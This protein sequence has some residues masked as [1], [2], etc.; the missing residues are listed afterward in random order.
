MHQL[1]ITLLAAVAG[2]ATLLLFYRAIRTEWPSNYV[3]VET[4]FGIVINRS[5]L[6]YFIFTLGPT[7]LVS[8]FAS[9]LADRSGGQ[10]VACALLIA[11]VHIIR[12]NGRHA[13]LVV[14]H[15]H[16]QAR[17][18]L[19]LVDGFNIFVVVLAAL[20]GAAGPGP[21]P[22][23]VPPAADFFSSLWTTAFVAVV[24]VCLLYATRH[25]ITIERLLNRSS[26][27]TRALEPVARSLAAEQQTEPALALA[28][29]Y[30]ENLQRPGW[31]R[32]LE[33]AKG[34]LWPAG[35]YGV[36]QI[37]SDRPFVRCRVDTTSIDRAI[38]RSTDPARRIRL[39]LGRSRARPSQLQR[40]RRIRRAGKPDLLP[41]L[42]C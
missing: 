25:R 22:A 6:R 7:Y 9:T 33:R 30:T 41:P 35:T 17:Y 27:E 31:I 20:A 11:G 37:T 10:G 18:A 28:I 2:A 5:F 16:D 4:D 38:G 32:W 42:L 15:R 24:G 26:S 29:L 23:I 21:F 19:L 1:E 12:N 8:L 3:S 14:R 40:Q 13:V 36:M 34:R 39:R